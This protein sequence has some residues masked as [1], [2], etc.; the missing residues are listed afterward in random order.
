MV[1]N[2]PQQRPRQLHQQQQRREFTV[3]T[4]AAIFL[5]FH[6][7][8]GPAVFP[9]SL[10]KVTEP[11]LWVAGDADRSQPTPMP[12]SPP[13]RRTPLTDGPSQRAASRHTRRRDRSRPRLAETP[14]PP[15]DRR[16]RLTPKPLCPIL[17]NGS[18]APLPRARAAGDREGPVDGIEPI[19]HAS[20]D[21]CARCNW[22]AC[23]RRCIAPMT[24]FPP[25]RH[26]STRPPSIRTIC[27]TWM[28]LANF[29]L[30]TKEHLRQSY[31]F[32]MFAEPMERIVRI[33]ASSGTTGK[34]TVV[35]Y[36]RNDLDTLVT[37][38]GSVDPSG[39]RPRV[40]QDSHR[41]RVWNCSPAASVPITAA[42]I[43]VP[44]SFRSAVDLPNARCR[45]SPT[46]S[47]ISSW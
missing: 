11:V 1:A 41:L 31:P 34:P 10:P 36:T 20:V 29:P 40:R 45:S 25:P 35:G 16:S 44:R 6:D 24:V 4:T 43:S 23:V 18:T 21:E 12:S 22:T 5:S 37:P 8:Q 46:S 2:R 13:C 15:A 7:I 9:R 32:G 14:C 26:A 27:A 47:L 19:E 17:P 39:G 3:Y 28:T 30:T 42:N 38:D 33:H